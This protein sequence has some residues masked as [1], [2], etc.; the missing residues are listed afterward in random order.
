[1]SRLSKG[2]RLVG[3]F[4]IKKSEIRRCDRGIVAV[5]S[6]K[7]SPFSLARVCDR[8]S[9][10]GMLHDCGGCSCH[11]H[12][13]TDLARSLVLLPAIRSVS[14]DTI[15][16][17]DGFSCREQILQQ[18]SSSSVQKEESP[19]C[20]PC[21]EISHWTTRMSSLPRWTHVAT[22]DRWRLASGS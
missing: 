11:N 2:T 17:V 18:R 7:R 15:I 22:L 10:P 13:V 3:T 6:E 21:D 14:D 9:R 8:G 1:M 19:K 16:V 12:R 20:Q 5:D 4:S